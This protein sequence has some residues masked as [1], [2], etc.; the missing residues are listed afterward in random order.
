MSDD[1]PR[2]LTPGNG[3]LITQKQVLRSI[4]PTPDYPRLCRGSAAA[5]A[6]HEPSRLLSRFTYTPSSFCAF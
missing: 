3:K 5:S 1:I 2:P 6:I 4:R